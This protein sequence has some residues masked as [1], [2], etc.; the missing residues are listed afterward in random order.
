LEVP[1]SQLL[2]YQNLKLFPTR[3]PHAGVP[4]RL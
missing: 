2:A 1:Y 4:V 3:W